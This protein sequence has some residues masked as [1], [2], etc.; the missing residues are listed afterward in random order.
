MPLPGAI[1]LTKCI[2][3]LYV[4]S[5]KEQKFKIHVTLLKCRKSQVRGFRGLVTLIDYQLLHL[6]DFFHP[7]IGQ[8]HQ[9]T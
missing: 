2:A 8:Q 6:D 9:I 3:L 5:R 4:V 1:G 7:F